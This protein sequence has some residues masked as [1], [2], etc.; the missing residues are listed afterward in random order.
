MTTVQLVAPGVYRYLCG[1]ANVYFLGKPGE[2]WM[3]VDTGLA[4][5]ERRII[6]AAEKIYGAGIRPRAIL[7]THGHADHAGSSGRLSE[8]WDVPVYA[9]RLEHPYLTRLSSYP[10]MDPT[11]GGAA[12]FAS[13][14][15][16]M[17]NVDLGPRLIDVDRD[18]TLPGATAW[19]W[20][21][22]SGHTPGHIAFYREEDGVLIAGD[23]LTTLRLNSA[24]GNVFKIRRIQG[25]PEATTTDWEA[26]GATVRRLARL[27]PKVLACGHGSPYLS[28]DN[29]T[30]RLSTFAALFKAPKRGRYVAAPALSD[31]TG[32]VSVPPAPLDP[33][34]PVVAGAAVV[35]VAVCAWLFA[36]QSQ[37]KST[38][39]IEAD[40]NPDGQDK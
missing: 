20:H 15:V 19:Q 26:A 13:R 6:S 2:P 39:N 24:I 30:V 37:S 14:F 7:L 23:A 10:P 31:E 9:H 27:S 35:S 1:F 12:G 18:N 17:P 11:I 32:V 8:R 29:T 34:R 40:T 5:S 38:N 28:G 16:P 3:L 33:L 36:R 22:A 21:D 25:P 4:G